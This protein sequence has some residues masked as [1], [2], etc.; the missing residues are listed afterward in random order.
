MS[1]N[2]GVHYH[3][4]IE[5]ENSR[6]CF[7]S[8]ISISVCIFDETLIKVFISR[9]VFKLLYNNLSCTTIN[10]FGF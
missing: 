5:L 1:F 9:R 8:Y 4:L 3:V 2:K 10:N 6:V 7:G